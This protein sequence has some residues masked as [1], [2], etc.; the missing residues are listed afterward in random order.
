MEVKE[1]VVQN[2]YQRRRGNVSTK[3]NRKYLDN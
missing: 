2:V 1:V 3:L